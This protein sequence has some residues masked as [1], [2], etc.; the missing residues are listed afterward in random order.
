MQIGQGKGQVDP[1]HVEIT[2]P[3]PR[4]GKP[5]APQR[6]TPPDRPASAST[7]VPPP[8]PTAPS[9]TRRRARRP[10]S[11]ETAG[12]CPRRNR[13]PRA[14]RR[15]ATRRPSP[16]R[17]PRS[18][19]DGCRAT[20]RLR[21]RRPRWSVRPST[22]PVA[23]LRRILP[24]RDLHPWL[25]AARFGSSRT[26]RLRSRSSSP[27]RRRLR[28]PCRAATPHVPATNCSAPPRTSTG[29]SVDVFFGDERWVSIHDPD[30]NEGMARLAFLD[31]VD[32]AWIHSLRHA[33]G[34]T[35]EEAAAAYD[36]LLA[37]LRPDRPRAPRAR[38][39]RPHRVALPGLR[40]HSTRPNAS[41]SP[42]ATTH[43]RTRA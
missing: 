26:S 30:S 6:Q 20:A 37:R 34:D 31:E 28:L 9:R 41:W 36:A 29:H 24:R 42:T 27:S 43:I 16:R 13:G 35:I 12:A 19:R 1:R 7:R 32:P 3:R 2:R 11:R 18:A 21:S 22:H 10:E 15:R 14:P 8:S 33:G 38:S 17:A 4:R 40:R 23:Q 39:R 25:F 5:T